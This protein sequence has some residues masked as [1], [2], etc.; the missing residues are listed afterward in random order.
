MNPWMADPRV[1]KA[2]VDAFEAER[3]ERRG[4]LANARALHHA[5]ADAFA[6]VALGVPADHPNTRT[7]LAIAAV[8]SYARAGDFG[9][10]VELARR[11]LAEGD[12]LGERGRREL[13]R[14]MRQYA[15]LLAPPP[16]EPTP[17]ALGPRATTQSPTL[18]EPRSDLLRG[19]YEKGAVEAEA[20]SILAVLAAR[21]ITVS[22]AVR[23]R[24]VACTD[25]PTLD[26]WLTRAAVVATAS[27][28]V[29]AKAPAR[30]GGGG[31]AARQAHKA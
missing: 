12:A 26:V 3:A 5:A 19:I 13:T 15:M 9:R 30:A 17:P 16:P 23:A 20:R 27:A 4:D 31:G 6:A 7:D 25:I 10:A 18:G 1:E 8:A 29:R 11:V 21:G 14:L 24:I 2:E 28:V 22:D